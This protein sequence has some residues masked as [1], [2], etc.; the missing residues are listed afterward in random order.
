[1]FIGNV[2]LQPQIYRVSMICQYT[3]CITGKSRAYSGFQAICV[4][5]IHFDVEIYNMFW[6][7]LTGY[8]GVKGSMPL[9]ESIF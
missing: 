6:L 4:T 7:R 3:K 2:Y 8:S 5:G 1:M 9:G